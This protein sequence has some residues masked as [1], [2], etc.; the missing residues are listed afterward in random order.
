[1][2]NRS[3]G[4]ALYVLNAALLISHQLDSAY[5]QAWELFH[6]PAAPR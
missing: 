6:I 1:M 3:W 2:V 5:L 4:P